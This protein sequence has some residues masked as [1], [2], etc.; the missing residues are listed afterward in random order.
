MSDVHVQHPALACELA[1]IHRSGRMRVISQTS[2]PRKELH[3]LLFNERWK[4]GA[5]KLYEVFSK[6][7]SRI[8][9]EDFLSGCSRSAGQ[10]AHLARLDNIGYNV[11]WSEHPKN[12][13]SAEHLSCLSPVR[14][15]FSLMWPGLLLSYPAQALVRMLLM[16]CRLGKRGQVSISLTR[17]RCHHV[18]CIPSRHVKVLRRIL[19]N[20]LQ[21]VSPTRSTTFLLTW[22]FH[23]SSF[24]KDMSC[25]VR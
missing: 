18:P 22:S 12:A 2:K 17:C 19:F 7:Q 23:S 24:C 9:N 3:N 4:A 20:K 11:F 16:T 10:P 13:F 25:D 1:Q 14:V 5:R 8:I 6:D 15:G 21:I